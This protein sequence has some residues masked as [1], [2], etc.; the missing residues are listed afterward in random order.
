MR[1]FP[2]WGR[3]SMILTADG[4]R[5]YAEEVGHGLTSVLVPQRIYLREYFEPV[6]VGQIAVFYDPRNRGLSETVHDAE[7]LSRGILHDM[8]DLEAVRL[9]YG[10]KQTAILTH[11]YFG[12][13][14]LLHAC[15]NPERVTRMVLIG[16]PPPDPSRIYPPELR[17]SDGTLEKFNDD[18]A[19]L[20]VRTSSLAAA[21]RC[22]AI[23]ELLRRLYVADPHMSGALHWEP[24][25][26]ANE[27]GFLPHFMKY[28]LPSLAANRLSE[29]ALSRISMPILIVHGRK[30]RSAPYGGA[31]DWARQLPNAR[32]LTIDEAAH[33][34]WI[35][36]PQVV[37]GAIRTF[38]AGGWP[39]G[40]ESL[41]QH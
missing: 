40:A 4:L 7:R 3:K 22:R 25:D 14:A 34:P 5:I 20:R 1:G 39:S 16:P 41:R 32:L 2:F 19:A 13:A 37:Y 11:S 35:E 15:A 33:V 27:A 31:L 23:W 21:D 38:L 17:S 9:H 26:I 24:C 29:E 12:I 10:L 6:T 30:D 36:A 18:F 8:E 28:V